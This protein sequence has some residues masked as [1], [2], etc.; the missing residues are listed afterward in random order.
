MMVSHILQVSPITNN[1]IH[2]HTNHIDTAT[3]T[4]SDSGSRIDT[5][6]PDP[7][8]ST[9]THTSNLS[10][11]TPT[12][13]TTA[14]TTTT[15]SMK[16]CDLNLDARSPRS[17]RQESP[18]SASALASS[19]RFKQRQQQQLPR[20]RQL[21]NSNSN[22]SNNTRN[23]KK[24]KPA[25]SQPPFLSFDVKSK[26]CAVYVGN[27][28]FEEKIKPCRRCWNTND[29]RENTDDN[30]NSEEDEKMKIL[31][32]D[33]N[34][35]ESNN[36]CNEV[37]VDNTQAYVEKNNEIK[38]CC[39]CEI[40]LKR[41]LRE[42]IN[43]AFKVAMIDIGIRTVRFFS[44]VTN[45]YDVIDKDNNEGGSG[46]SS[47][48]DNDNDN[49]DVKNDAINMGGNQQQQHQHRLRRRLLAACVEFDD[50]KN[51]EYALALK[52]TVFI[53]NGPS[54]SCRA[55]LRMRRWTT[56]P[57]QHSPKQLL[58]HPKSHPLS[59]ITINS[60]TTTTSPREYSNNR[61]GSK[62]ENRCDYDR[63]HDHDENTKVSNTASIT[64]TGRIS[65][66]PFSSI[67][68][69][70]AV[71]VG[72]LPSEITDDA[73]RLF[74]SRRMSKAF[75]G[76]TPPDIIRIGVRRRNVC[77]KIEN[78][79]YV[80]FQDPKV[81]YRATILKNRRWYANDNDKV[82]NDNE[83]KNDEIK[84]ESSSD[85]EENDDNKKKEDETMASTS[86]K[87]KWWKMP[88]L[89]IEAWDSN[90]YKMEDFFFSDNNGG[91]N[92]N[93]KNPIGNS[94]A[95][96]PPEENENDTENT[97][98]N[99]ED[100]KRDDDDDDDDD[101][102]PQRISNIEE[103]DD[104]DVDAI[105]MANNQI[106]RK[107]P[108]IPLTGAAGTN[109]IESRMKG[110]L[111]CK[112]DDKIPRL[113][114]LFAVEGRDGES[115]SSS[116][117]SS[118]SFGETRSRLCHGHVFRGKACR[119]HSNNKFRRKNGSY[120]VYAHINS[121]EDIKDPHDQ[122]AILYYVNNNDDVEFVPGE[123]C[124]PKEYLLRQ[125]EQLKS[126]KDAT[127]T[128]SDKMMNG[129]NTQDGRNQH[130]I[131]RD[132]E[133][134][135][136]ATHQ[137]LREEVKVTHYHLDE[138]AALQKQRRNSQESMEEMVQ[139]LRSNL[140][141]VRQEL[142]SI[143]QELRDSEVIHQSL[144]QGRQQE[145][146]ESEKATQLLLDKITKLELALSE[147]NQKWKKSECVVEESKR[148]YAS[149]YE[150]FQQEQKEI[151]ATTYDTQKQNQSWP[152]L[153]QTTFQFENFLQTSVPT[154]MEMAFMETTNGKS[155]K[156]EERSSPTKS[157]LDLLPTPAPTLDHQSSLSASPVSFENSVDHTPTVMELQQ[158]AVDNE[159]AVRLRSEFTLV[160]SFYANEEVVTDGKSTVTRYLK[161]P[162]LDGG[163]EDE[164]GRR[165]IHIDLVLTIPNG[166]P[167]RGI[168]GIKTQILHGYSVESSSHSRARIELENCLASLVSVC[169]W[170]AQVC[171]G[172]E[173]LLNI[174]ATAENW[175][176]N[177]WINIKNEKSY[178]LN[179]S[180]LNSILESSVHSV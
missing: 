66:L 8:L 159:T 152:Q 101:T 3:S 18:W 32:S 99:S 44:V 95:S 163:G 122:M 104:D 89:E 79:I 24:L 4:I 60:T 123:G 80:E 100:S 41:F 55:T 46:S 120:C 87:M 68:F 50:P 26:N 109:V 165:Y 20:S 75:H 22:I 64:H 78:D 151:T 35:N 63:D 168:I 6:S 107:R 105:A 90:K 149:L 36:D 113:D 174:L 76:V 160:G 155:K 147:T 58:L 49:D 132:L 53:Y 180:D 91:N 127:T 117:S 171:E 138:N 14:T 98:A 92:K 93:K 19:P 5:S 145:I 94:E 177:D 2:P 173:A 164:M 51:A 34:G 154:L 169:R 11:F 106:Q 28:P 37:T 38:G 56:E 143:Q 31:V 15:H 30:C 9:S 21:L 144:Q 115:S 133:R 77:N 82:G 54:R 83:N 42:R 124:T 153:S 33:S 40:E 108:I 61:G 65:P 114:H 1:I 112:N 7:P 88:M 128:T 85:N 172:K 67:T 157:R 111:V 13:T 57:P 162:I 110:F 179:G 142:A 141:T 136:E 118:S 25:S 39:D 167:S 139:E 103:D 137:K 178:N 140:S 10:S 52:N 158:H 47:A 156:K 135:L 70:S 48:N 23:R 27:I 130:D 166:Y 62:T 12:P 81:A 131:I 96:A 121:F 126:E 119:N 17:S 176:K 150:K 170:E 74:F 175:V 129:E 146:E 116:S 73:V 29:D 148:E 86:I 72:N 45:M 69:S 134:E 71:H 102:S 59:P 16:D 125:L 97:N 161:L 43:A 84:K